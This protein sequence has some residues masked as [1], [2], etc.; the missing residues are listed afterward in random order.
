MEKEKVWR[1]FAALS[2]KNQRRVASFIQSLQEEN[3]VVDSEGGKQPCLE[4]EPFVGMWEG[5][6]DMADSS[7]WLRELREREWMSSDD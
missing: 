4:E 3:A 6:E 1:E 5:R 7:S 2:E